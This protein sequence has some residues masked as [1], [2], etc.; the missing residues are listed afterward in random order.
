V[1]PSDGPGTATAEPR[2]EALLLADDGFM[3]NHG[4]TI[5]DVGRL[6]ATTREA[7]GQVQSNF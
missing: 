6:L 3:Q 5:D 4:L 7:F 2:L 1:L